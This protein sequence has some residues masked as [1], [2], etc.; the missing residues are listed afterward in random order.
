MAQKGGGKAS[1]FARSLE[2]GGAAVQRE[3][4][5]E[6]VHENLESPQ[7]GA[8]AREPGGE[9][10]RASGR[11]PRGRQRPAKPVRI[12]VDLDADRHRFL[13]RYAA[14]EGVRGTEVVRGLL[15]LLEEDPELAA[16]LS[17][18]LMREEA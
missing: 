17:E 10:E 16:R 14:D 8:Q 18:R 3:A 12:T 1:K 15:S 11:T 9:P 2:R 7:A 4:P 13:R 5:E 6:A